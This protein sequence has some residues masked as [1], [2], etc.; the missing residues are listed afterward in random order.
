M[1]TLLSSE[2]ATSIL[3]SLGY[4]TFREYQQAH[5]LPESGILDTPT[6]RSLLQTRTCNLPEFFSLDA[7]APPAKW[8]KNNITW[9]LS[10]SF[11]LPGFSQ[12]TISTVF[13]WAF[14]DWAQN[15]ALK[16]SQIPFEAEPDILINSGR[17]DSAG[18]TLAWSELPSGGNQQLNQKYDNAEAFVFSGNPQAGR[19]DLGAVA[20]HEIGHALGL[21]HAPNNIIALLNSIYNPRIRSLQ[22]WDIAEI[23][24]RYGPPEPAQPPSGPTPTPTPEPKEIFSSQLDYRVADGYIVVAVPLSQVAPQYRPKK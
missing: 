19:I 10:R 5:F 6:E 22:P 21:S 8:N 20:K 4:F 12:E 2:K 11:A 17:I 1:T 24:R 7:N 14:S 16:F 15:A 13:E 18:N 9:R 23:Q 3:Q